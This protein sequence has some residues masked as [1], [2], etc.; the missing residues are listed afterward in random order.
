MSDRWTWPVMGS[1]VSL[2]IPTGPGAASPG[3]AEVAAHDVR[4]LLDEVE[5]RFSPFRPDS[6][7]TRLREG[8]L[9]PDE[10]SS[11]MDEVLGA[12]SALQAET[13]GAFHPF[14]PLGRFDPTGYVKGWGIQ[15][16]VARLLDD[17][18]TD[19]FLGIGGDVQTI[20]QVR[21]RG[22]AAVRPWR[23]AIADPVDRARVV[24]IVQAPGSG[25]F[26]VATSGDAQRG[27]H[28]WPAP[29]NGI[30]PV[31]AHGGSGPGPRRP[32]RG[33]TSITVVGPE[34]RL[35]DAY[36][37][38]IWAEAGASGLDDAWAWLGGTGY[39][40]LSVEQDGGIRATAGMADLLVRAAA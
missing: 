39:E 1:A 29:S 16:A 19:A 31:R 2:L 40:A 18:V 6:E 28:I 34:L 5:R 3:V 9:Q 38:A 36:A 13:L 11:P 26:A 24:A 32:R 37:T 20:G 33:P 27:A 17:G 7:L 23:V 21:D 10:P 15:R 12:V 8:R 14:D 25:A 22:P 4:D 30:G 35:A